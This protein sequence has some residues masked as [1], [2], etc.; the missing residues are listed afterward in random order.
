MYESLG[1][2]IGDGVFW[3]FVEHEDEEFG[4]L[5]ELLVFTYIIQFSHQFAILVLILVQD[6]FHCDI[7]GFEVLLQVVL[8]FAF[9]L[10]P[11]FLGLGGY[12]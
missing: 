2:V 11:S 3:F 5:G 7:D 8:D 10:C 4:F 9:E 1:D 6:A 12:G